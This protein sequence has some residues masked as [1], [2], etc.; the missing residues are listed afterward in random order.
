MADYRPLIPAVDLSQN[1]YTFA[2]AVDHVLDV[3]ALPDR[4]LHGRAA[5]RAVLEAYRDLPYRHR[6]KYY[7]RRGQIR[8]AA[9]QTSGTIEYDHTGGAYERQVT[10]SGATWP[11]DARFY[12]II[13]DN[14]HY[15]VED[16][17]SSTVI[18]LTQGTNPGADVAAGTSYTL[19]RSSY[20]FPVNYRRG[21]EL[22]QLDDT[23]YWPEFVSAKQALDWQATDP[24]PDGE[25]LYY[26]I[27]S[28]GE[29]FGGMAVE[30]SPPPSEAKVYDF[31]Y[32]AAPLPLKHFNGK[33]EYYDG[34]VSV[35]GTTVTGTDT[36]FTDSMLGA[37]IRFSA[38]AERPSGMV[39]SEEH[40]NP[41]AEQRVITAVN[42]ET[43]LTIDSAVAGSYTDVGYTIG[44]ALDI[45]P[46]PMLT[47][48]HKLVELNFARF[49]DGKFAG[50]Q[51]GIQRRDADYRQS[52][53]EAM[54]ADNKSR[55]MTEREVP[56]AGSLIEAASQYGR[57][58]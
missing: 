40:D 23:F 28:A 34:T 24:E 26:T 55:D 14:K 35:S 53:R 39:G 32:E 51:A 9:S 15:D 20:P 49:G 57:I 52:L 16:Y 21:S 45:D 38:T 27:R 47:A 2:D 6:W 10:L 17:K 56:R 12:R 3:Y 19:Y 11:T 18:T 4:S 44:S 41:F 37:I 46:G 13:I 48:F 31:I 54:A 7:E 29:Y 8:T 33:P 5:R 22:V 43:S 30:F 50:G 36:V 1:V 42:S 25:P 58:T